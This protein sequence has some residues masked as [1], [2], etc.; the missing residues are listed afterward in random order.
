M[1]F[2]LLATEDCDIKL[3]PGDR[4]NVTHNKIEDG[5]GDVVYTRRVACIKIKRKM[6][7][8]SA[9]VYEFKNEFGLKSGFIGVIG[10]NND[11]T[12]TT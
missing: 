2:K 7:A 10:E 3:Q 12:A 9:R 1:S 5:T 11:S 6:H 4:L 8:T